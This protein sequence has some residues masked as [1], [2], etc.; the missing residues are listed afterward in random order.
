ML[1]AVLPEIRAKKTL[2]GGPLMRKNNVMCYSTAALLTVSVL[3]GGGSAPADST[4]ASSAAEVETS[5]ES[6]IESADS[7]VSDTTEVD[8]AQIFADNALEKLLAKYE[9]VTV[10]TQYTYNG[11]EEN[12]LN[13]TVQYTTKDG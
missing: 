7:D 4:P 5:A 2:E 3:A 11:D 10:T 1:S 9:T 12:L 8:L 13:T 6:T